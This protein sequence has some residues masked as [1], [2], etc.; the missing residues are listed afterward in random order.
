MQTA[1]KSWPESNPDRATTYRS[2]EE[3]KVKDEETNSLGIWE[4]FYECDMEVMF[5]GEV[6]LLRKDQDSRTEVLVSS[7]GAVAVQS[8]VS[9]AGVSC[10]RIRIYTDPWDFMGVPGFSPEEMAAVLSA[11]AFAV[12]E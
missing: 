8:M 6:V 10:S 1:I 3:I 11:A 9:V 2:S 5:E 12:R 4:T 7:C